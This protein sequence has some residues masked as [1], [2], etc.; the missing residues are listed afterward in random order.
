MDG[1]LFARAVPSSLPS[2]RESN[3]VS[4]NLAYQLL[5]LRDAGPSATISI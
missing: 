4:K 5:R 1:Q 3:L 2:G